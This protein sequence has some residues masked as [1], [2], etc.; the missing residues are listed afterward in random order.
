MLNPDCLTP[1]PT[2]SN[3]ILDAS[4]Y[5]MTAIQTNPA[6]YS[7][8]ICFK[9]TITPNG[10]LPLLEFHKQ[11]NIVGLPLDCSAT[12]AINPS[13]VNPPSITYNSGSLPLSIAADYKSIFTDALNADCPVTSCEM[14]NPDCL[15]PLPTQSNIILDASSYGMTA[16][17][18]N[19][20]GYSTPICFKCTI[21]PNG[22]LPLLEFHKQINIVGLPLDCSDSLANVSFVNPTFSFNSI[23]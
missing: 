6:G 9:C 7:T 3:I 4:S 14:L 1:L 15:T 2:Q 18:T 10:G 11:I 16:I 5:G 22:G 21:T 19:P 13:F 17:Q 12:L 8:P 23:V 20:A